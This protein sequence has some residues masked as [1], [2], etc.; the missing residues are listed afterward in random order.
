MVAEIRY[1]ESAGNYV[2]LHTASAS[3]LLHG[4]LAGVEHASTRHASSAC[5][6][7]SS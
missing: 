1:L 4:T 3:P 5:T 7:R 2:R 6:A